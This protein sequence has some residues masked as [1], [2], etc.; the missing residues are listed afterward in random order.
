MHMY[1]CLVV[2]WLVVSRS[3]SRRPAGHP[4]ARQCATDGTDACAVCSQGYKLR[5]GKCV[6][7]AW[8]VIV[9][10]RPRPRRSP[11]RRVAGRYRSN[12]ASVAP[13]HEYS[14]RVAAWPDPAGG[15]GPERARQ[16]DKAEGA[17]G[18]LAQ[19]RHLCRGGIRLDPT[20]RQA[21]ATRSGVRAR[22]ADSRL[23][24]GPR[25]RRHPRR[26]GRGPLQ[27]PARGVHRAAPRRGDR[28][29]PTMAAERSVT[30]YAQDWA[31]RHGEAGEWRAVVV[32]RAAWSTMATASAAHVLARS[33]CKCARVR[34]DTGATPERHACR[35]VLFPCVCVWRD[36][37]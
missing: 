4:C 12:S 5:D 33:S 3:R 21:C 35:R 32:G 34:G 23:R 29:H 7:Q 27:D 13:D 2:A 18:A 30:T 37:V 28:A 6:N 10:R 15:G 36:V 20:Q 19:A 25:P 9:R 22:R 14:V 16:A 8:Y 24:R 31:E 26:L 1:I 11:G 17:Q